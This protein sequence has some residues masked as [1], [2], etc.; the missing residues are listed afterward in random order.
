MRTDGLDGHGWT[1]RLFVHTGGAC[2]HTFVFGAY[3]ALMVVA[4]NAGVLPIDGA[5]VARAIAASVTM[6]AALLLVLRVIVPDLQSRAAYLSIVFIACSFYGIVASATSHPWAAMLYVGASAAVAALAV[7]LPHVRASTSTWNV[8]ACVL[9]AVHAYAMMPV[10]RSSE[11]WRDAADDLIAG[12]AGSGAPRLDGPRP[13]IYHIVLDGFGRPDVLKE[14]YGLDLDP[15]VAALESRGFAVPPSGRSN[16]AQT[17]LSLASSLNLSYL[18]PIASDL[19]GTADRRVL[20][21][22]IQHNALMTLARRAG[23]GITA[24]GSNYSATMRLENADT[25]LCE[26]YGLGETAL[27]ILELTPLG[28]L[29]LD[30]WTYAAHRRKLT[31][32]FAHLERATDASRPTMVFAHV[33]APHPPF[34]FEADGGRR[35]D[36]GRTFSFRDGSHYAGSSAEYVA[37]YREQTRFLASKVL[38]AVDAILSRPGPAPVIVLHGDH[39]PASTWNWDHLHEAN[40]RERLS[41]FSAYYFP[42][43]NPPDLPAQLSPVNGLRILANRYFGTG[44]PALPERAFASTWPR[45]YDLMP[46][47]LDDHGPH[48]PSDADRPTGRP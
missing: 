31:A 27:A 33:I 43:D 24:I 11:P 47:A 22:L 6:T 9:L 20:A 19:R 29:P 3:P 4:S 41:I 2:F 25:C 15:F 40:V 21:Y 30:R 39:G 17:Y 34:V 48:L 10:L 46:V 44:L 37:G 26:Q 23:Y 12:V 1:P 14:L 42:D 45:P 7:R 5:A 35:S 28:A 36:A 38:A 18:D 32:A 16:Y 13:D 8:G